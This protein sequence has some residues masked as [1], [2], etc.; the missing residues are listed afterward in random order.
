M[1]TLTRVIKLETRL[2]KNKR[3][4]KQK[5]LKTFKVLIMFTLI[6]F[7][8]VGLNVVNNTIIQLNLMDYP[9][10]L[11]YDLN[12]RSFDFLGKTYFINLE[13]LKNIF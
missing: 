7:M 1:D 3:I 12:N 9:I 4:K 11:R 10:L 6:Y 5:K 2:E 8:I 13:P